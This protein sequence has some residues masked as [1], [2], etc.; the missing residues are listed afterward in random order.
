MNIPDSISHDSL[1]AALELKSLG[2]DDCDESENEGDSVNSVYRMQLRHSLLNCARRAHLAVAAH[3]L[4][5][6]PE[7]EIAN[8]STV[9]LLVLLDQKRAN[10]TALEAERFRYWA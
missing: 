1:L 6:L 10:M 3:E 7:S 9:E 2:L 8:K 4:T 5:G